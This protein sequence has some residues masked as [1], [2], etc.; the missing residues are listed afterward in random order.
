MISGDSAG[1]GLVLLTQQ[2]IRDL[3]LPKPSCGVPISPWT[4]LTL[5][6]ISQV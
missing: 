5:S 1:G 3:G 4:D 6:G 2:K